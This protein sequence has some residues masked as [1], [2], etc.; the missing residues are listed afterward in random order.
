LRYLLTYR[1]GGSGSLS[2]NDKRTDDLGLSKTV[3][4]NV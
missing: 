2:Q 3:W 1:G 4:T